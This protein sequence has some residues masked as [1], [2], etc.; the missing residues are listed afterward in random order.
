VS[1]K[2][3]KRL[4]VTGAFVVLF[5]LV[6]TIVVLAMNTHCVDTTSGGLGKTSMPACAGYEHGADVG[7]ALVVIG[8]AFIAGG[9]LASAIVQGQRAR[10]GPQ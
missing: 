7:Y 8:A 4:A 2:L 5:G 6:A 10:R 3:P 9:A 1:P